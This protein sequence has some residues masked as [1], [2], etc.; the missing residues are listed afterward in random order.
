MKSVRAAL[1]DRGMPDE[2]ISLKAYWRTGRG[3]AEH[4]EPDKSD[5]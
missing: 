4:G 3:N 5:S 2:Q 1:L